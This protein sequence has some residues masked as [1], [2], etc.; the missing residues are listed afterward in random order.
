LGSASCPVRDHRDDF[1]LIEAPTT[2]TRLKS[3]GLFSP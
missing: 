2:A 1:E 3:T